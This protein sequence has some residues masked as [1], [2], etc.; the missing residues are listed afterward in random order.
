MLQA[1]RLSDRELEIVKKIAAGHRTPDIAEML[2]I[3]PHT[4]RA[5]RK[6]IMRKMKVHNCTS[7]VSI[8]TKLAWI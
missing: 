8:C 4:V 6:N 7:V 3:S 2:G 1:V 5:H